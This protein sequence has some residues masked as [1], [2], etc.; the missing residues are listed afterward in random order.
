MKRLAVLLS[1]G[2]LSATACSAA[3][4]L[5]LSSSSS[6][7]ASSPSSS[8]SSSAAS[9]SSAAAPTAA[10][11]A[12]GEP[13]AGL[14]EYATRFIRD[15][16]N[17]SQSC[18]A[19][20]TPAPS[21]ES[22]CI[23]RLDAAERLYKSVDEKK[24]DQVE[25][26]RVFLA[27]LRKSVEQWRANDKAADARKTADYNLSR[28]TS[29]AAHNADSVLRQLKDARAG[30]ITSPLISFEHRDAGYVERALELLQHE[31][32]TVAEIAK[33]CAAGAGDKDL[34]DLATNRDKYWAKLL[35]LQF[36]AILAERLQAWTNAIDG[37]KHDGKVAVI[38][39]NTLTKPEKLGELGRD[40]A[41][42]GKVLGQ[43]NP[44]AKIDGQLA[45]LRDDFVA[46]VKDKQGV[47]M[48]AEHASG[49]RYQDP[50]IT[51]AVRAINGLSLVKVGANEPTWEVIRG[52]LDQP[53]QRNHYVW[54][55][56]KKP[57][58]GFCRLYQFTIVEQHMGGGRY[59]APRAD[60]FGDP[61][62]Y[63]SAC[64]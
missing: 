59:G 37:V 54:A 5:G 64:K 6:T 31:M 40:L 56:M 15:A 55:L 42:I 30:K 62:F 57:G 53:V 51:Q 49:A 58:D 4:K 14:S 19:G 35:V 24:N 48:W 13:G 47:N 63:V 16:N 32:P 61:E 18:P 60:S 29:S 38:N 10:K 9:P 27:E 21:Y 46:A 7:S 26:G 33:N 1:V 52:A 44:K 22:E 20:P 34:C 17:L 41:D 50:A 12:I 8:S 45:K 39:Y 2:W 28:E 25:R 36:D 43:P 3:A 23:W 11:P